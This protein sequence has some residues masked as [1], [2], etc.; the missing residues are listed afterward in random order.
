M[1][2]KV[3]KII[4]TLGLEPLTFEGGYFRSTYRS[5]HILEKEHLPEGYNSRRVVSSAI[6]Y[7][8]TPDTCSRMH[9][10]PTEEIFHFYA[11]DPVQMLQ[12]SEHGTG[13]VITI[14]PD[15]LAGM[16]PQVVVPKNTWQGTRLVDGGEYALLGATVAPGFEEADF[17]AAEEADLLKAYPDFKEFIRQLT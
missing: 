4:Q 8:L 6:Y 3:K 17:I 7:L 12:L 1:T 13:K 9:R 15:V 11:G 10:L 2:E 14:G 16:Q 5:A